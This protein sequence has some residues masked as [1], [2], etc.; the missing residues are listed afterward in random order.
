MHTRVAAVG[1]FLASVKHA[2]SFATAS[3]TQSKNLASEVGRVRLSL[4]EA[5]EIAEALGK[6]PW[7]GDDGAAVVAA[8]VTGASA[9]R[10]AGCRKSLQDYTSFVHFFQQG[11]WDIFLSENASSSLKLATMMDHLSKLGLRCPTEITMQ[12]ITGF[13]LMISEGV[14]ESKCMS[15]Q[16][17]GAMLKHLKKEVKARCRSDP[18]DYVET[19]PVDSSVFAAEHSTMSASVFSLGP[20]VPCKLDFNEW[21]DISQTVAMRSSRKEGF[22]MHASGIQSQPLAEMAGCFM[23][24]LQQMQQLQVATVAALQSFGRHPGEVVPSG[25]GKTKGPLQVPVC[26]VFDIA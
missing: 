12:R 7:H 14:H 13:F 3:A 22:Q 9:P 16:Q 26:F 10:A 6:V 8:L 25:C 19:L 5:T 21:L 20:P 18:L 23:Q 17:K 11:Q 15:Q 2:P 4:Q 24:Q 1:R